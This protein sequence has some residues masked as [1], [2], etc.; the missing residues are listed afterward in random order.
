MGN[1]FAI[2]DKKTTT[3]SKSAETGDENRFGRSGK[4]TSIKTKNT[5]RRDQSESTGERRKT[6]KIPG[7]DQTVRT[8]QDIP[9]QCKKI[10][11]A[12]RRRKGKDIPVT[13]CE[14]GKKI[15]EEI[16]VNG[17]TIIKKK[18]NR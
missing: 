7:Q 15:L 1:Q 12:R 3:T 14:G 2:T 4:S 13:R 18:P 9:K 10:Q 8:K 16:Y 17:K 11:P 6:K 5:N